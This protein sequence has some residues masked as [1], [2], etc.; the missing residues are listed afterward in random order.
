MAMNCFSFDLSKRQ[1]LA[2][3]LREA[4]FEVNVL[5]DDGVCATIRCR[6]QGMETDLQVHPGYAGEPTRFLVS[7]LVAY[8]LFGWKRSREFFARIESALLANGGRPDPD[9]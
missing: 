9:A 7:V 6:S 1:Q 5:I 2:D 4:G 3:G 8:R